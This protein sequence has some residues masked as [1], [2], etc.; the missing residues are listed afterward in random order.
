MS[1]FP[2][3]ASLPPAPRPD[4]PFMSA[5][6]PPGGPPAS[7]QSASGRSASNESATAAGHLRLHRPSRKAAE[8]GSA[9]VAAGKPLDR[10]WSV[11][12]S[13][14]GWRVDRGGQVRPTAGTAADGPP[15]TMQRDDAQGLAEAAGALAAELE[16]GEQAMRRTGAEL[17]ARA[18]V[19]VDDEPA[20][21]ADRMDEVLRDATAATGTTAAIVSML[22]DDT[23]QMFVVAS[24]GD[25]ASV[26]DLRELRGSRGDLEAMVSSIAAADDFR[27]GGIDTWNAPAGDRYAAGICVCLT[28]GDVPVGTLWLLSEVTRPWTPQERAAAAMA[29]RFLT[30]VV[31]E[32]LIVSAEEAPASESRQ[33]PTVE[34]GIARWQYL[35]LPTG[36]KLATDWRVDG[37][38]ETN[39]PIAAGW[40]HW[41]VLPD[42]RLLLAMADSDDDPAAA[43][44]S[45]TFARA[46]LMAHTAYRHDTA[47]MMRRL[48]DTMWQSS[49]V[50][51]PLSV[52]YA[53]VE[54][55]SGH[56][57]VSV[58]GRVSTMIANRYGYRPVCRDT[59][60][61]LG[62]HIDGQFSA[63]CFT[64]ARGETLLMHGAGFA[65][66]GIH[67]TTIGTALR[68]AAE[69]KTV[70]PLASLRRQ[71]ADVPMDATRTAATLT[72]T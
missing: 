56:G 19:L 59:D 37:W 55:D 62:V 66:D 13:A 14:T 35:S 58:A 33:R 72:R 4:A 28:R 63:N 61:A 68:S 53:L 38:L 39:A 51:A 65:D 8:K 48:S 11:F 54:P 1:P 41:D 17:A 10:Y 50:A 57:W 42:G 67:Q 60:A 43:A 70:Y 69:S 3:N 21:L 23:Q 64:L 22:D 7:G 45:T 16:R 34:S 47:T 6:L 44:M 46:A 36:S 31:D 27:G 40:H 18:M 29:G 71:F 32:S 25:A 24:L 20:A 5:N 2:P 52:A 12:N 26:G 9:G 30:T 15:P 49:T